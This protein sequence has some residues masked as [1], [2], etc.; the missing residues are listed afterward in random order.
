MKNCF[1]TVSKTIACCAL[2]AAAT[3]VLHAGTVAEEKTIPPVEAPAPGLKIHGLI[4]LEFSDHYITP[5]GLHV[6][7]QGVIF[8]PL[9]LL[10]WNLYSSESG[11]LN[12]VTLTTG[13]WNSWHTRKSGADPHQWNEID[14]ILGLSFKF[15]KNFT[16]DAFYTAFQSM[17]DSY[18]TSTNLDLKLSYDDSSLLGAFAL[19]PYVEFFYEVDELAVV[20]GEKYSYYFQLGINPSYTFKCGTK[21]ELPTS[22][23]LTADD[24]Y[25][26]FDGSDGGSGVGVF[27][28][29]LKVSVPLKFVPASY[30]FWKAYAGVQYYYLNNEGIIDGNVL[31]GATADRE[32]HLVQFHGGITI[33]F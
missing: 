12:D 14:P 4:Q 8:Q 21:I 33:F 27:T 29:Q 30:G 24:F 32:E 23:T 17:T 10:F 25:T 16:L 5:R 31:L 11:F 22:V 26:R 3:P 2:L 6:E 20:L 19:H 13:V 1:R 18:E 9:V 7:N 28:T 15:A